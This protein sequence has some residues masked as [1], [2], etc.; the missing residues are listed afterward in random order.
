MPAHPPKKTSPR[1]IDR[2]GFFASCLTSNPCQHT[3]VI[4]YKDGSAPEPRHLG[5]DKIAQ[6]YA[7]N[8]FQVPPHFV[9]YP[10]KIPTLPNGKPKKKIVK[11]RAKAKIVLTSPRPAQYPGMFAGDYGKIIW[12]AENSVQI[13]HGK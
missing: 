7:D 11:A 8:G 10:V 1:P 4:F 2:I 13:W 3:I 5:G 12:E 9:K 6:L